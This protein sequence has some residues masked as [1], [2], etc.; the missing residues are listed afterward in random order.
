MKFRCVVLLVMAMVMLPH[1]AMAQVAIYGEGGASELRGGPQGDFLYGG[2]AG[3]LLDLPKAIHHVLL[4]ADIQGRF[5]QKNGE[6]L[7]A[8]TIG[9]R[10]SLKPHIL[11][12]S[13][14]AQFDVGFGKYNDGVNNPAV[15]TLYGGQAGF[16][17]RISSRFDAV[18][19]YSYELYGYNFGAYEP[20]SYNAGV[21][22]HF[23]KREP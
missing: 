10:L 23:S 14:F 11:K 1:A 19:D 5:V 3:V 4:S 12:L 21:I 13:P 7:Q 17:R 15:D 2:Q 8:I 6:S 9:P 20:Q 22:Y 16:T 18:I